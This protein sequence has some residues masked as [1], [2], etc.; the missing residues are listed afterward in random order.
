MLHASLRFGLFLILSGTLGIPAIASK[1]E[2]GFL[3]RTLTLNNRTYK[4]QVFVPDNWSPNQ[5]W[6]IILFLHGAVERGS[7]GL[8]QTHVGIAPAIREGRSRF[9]ALS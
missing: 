1:Q 2:T 5:K 9:P 6:P 7:D 8:L 3:D 4:Y